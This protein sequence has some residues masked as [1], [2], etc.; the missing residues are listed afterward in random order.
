M[1]K[2]GVQ[3]EVPAARWGTMAR[4]WGRESGTWERRIRAESMTSP[5]YLVRNRTLGPLLEKNP[6]TP[7]SPRGEGLRLLHGLETN[8]ATSLQTPQ[9]A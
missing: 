6:E 9:E 3:Q 2:A 1:R 7:P 5:S 4:A 8:L